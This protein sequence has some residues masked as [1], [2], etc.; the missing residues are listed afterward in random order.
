MTMT[1]TKKITIGLLLMVFISLAFNIFA[2]GKPLE[3]EY[4]E[5]EG[6]KPEEV[7]TPIPEYVK[8]IFNF[9]I[10]ASGIIA[11]VV[12]VIGGFQWFTSAGNLE[13]IK[14]AKERIGAALLGLLILFG[15][16]LILTTI[17]PNLVIFKL[18]RLR[19]IISTLPKG[20][21]VCKE[22]VEVDRAWQL[23][24]NFKD[25]KEYWQQIEIKKEL[26][27]IFDNIALKCYSVF[28]SGNIISSFDN[29]ITDIYFI[30][31]EQIIDEKN[32]VA[33]YGAI[34]Y[35]DSGFEGK[36]QP[37]YD[38]LKPGT[39]A[40]VVMPEH[41]ERK[42]LLVNP[43]SIKPFV[44]I[45]QHHE[46]KFQVVL[47]QEYNRN[48]GVLDANGLKLKGWMY[49]LN[50]SEPYTDTNGNGQW[51]PGEPYADTNGNGQ[52]DPANWFW[53]WDWD[54]IK[55]DFCKLTLARC[56]S[57][58]ASPRSMQVYGNFLA[59]LLT[60]DGKSDTFY[61][62]VD[63]NLDDNLNIIKWVDCDDYK[64][65]KTQLVPVG[66]GWGM[67]YVNKCAQPAVN[68]LIIISASLY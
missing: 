47:Y 24:N 12:L 49:R 11:L 2:Q 30:P 5:V 65:K 60:P 45:P 6:Q 7:T 61:N 62:E 68:R 44:L 8:Y 10:W 64:S 51:D 35:E 54:R 66:S 15:S 33:D 52:W 20:V 42:A 48:E 13:R 29:K 37:I 56:S 59:I 16:Y 25:T 58:Y 9:L 53:E 38:H 50:P 34:L 21:L 41:I 31:G 32:Y 36:S 67:G 57:D 63:N 1:M 17:N 26:D 23:E 28:G 27:T 4:P 3:V 18:E 46:E 43:S 55:S 40:G 14:E 22:E 39:L 19:P